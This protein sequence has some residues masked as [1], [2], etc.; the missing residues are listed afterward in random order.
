MNKD[1]TQDV[2]MSTESLDVNEVKDTQ[3][4][5]TKDT[6]PK[7]DQG[8]TLSEIMNRD[9][10]KRVIDKRVTQAITTAV[11]N[12][13][14][15]WE[16]EAKLSDEERAQRVL[17]EREKALS[18]KEAAFSLKERTAETKL[19]LIHKGLPACIA[20]LIAHATTDDEEADKLISAI[21]SDWNAQMAEK[22]KAGAR[23][24]PAQS[25]QKTDLEESRNTSLADFARKN[26][27]VK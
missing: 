10:V 16:E 6:E 7:A 20:E 4:T 25:S 22:T 13:R 8:L 23:Q 26:R 17:A 21:E 1:Q 15:K 12:E 18:E 3:Q 24:A 14:I 5:P 2:D 11:S 27:K 19:K 9:D